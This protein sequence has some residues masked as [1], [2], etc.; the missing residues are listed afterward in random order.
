MLTALA[1]LEGLPHETL[2][3]LHAAATVEAALT[4]LEACDS[5][6]ADRLRRRM[7]AAVETRA[8]AYLASHGVP[9]MVVGAALF[10]RSRRLRACGRRGAELL[11][12]F[13][14]AP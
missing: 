11:G 12:A 3:Q 5:G 10:D 13:R 9:S 8:T 6:A 1:A 7:A 14:Q 4:E 2:R